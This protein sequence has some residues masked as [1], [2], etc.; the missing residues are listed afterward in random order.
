MTDMVQKITI[1]EVRQTTDERGTRGTVVG[2]CDSQST[3]D[4]CAKGEGWW[5][6]MGMVTEMS[7]LVVDGKVWALRQPEPVE[8]LNLTAV[9][10]LKPIPQSELDTNLRNAALAKLSPDE[11][12]VLG[13][14]T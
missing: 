9:R 10:A 2:Y 12:R 4:A 8:V 11:R 14:A 5:G 3:A 6:G 1:F 13:Y 7:A